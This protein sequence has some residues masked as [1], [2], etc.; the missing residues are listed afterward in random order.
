MVV[1]VTAPV[2]KEVLSTAGL[3]AL[4]QPRLSGEKRHNPA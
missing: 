4:W 3:A 1:Y 2:V